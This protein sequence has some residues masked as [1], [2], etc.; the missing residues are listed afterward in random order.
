[1][2]RGMSY[3]NQPITILPLQATWLM[4]NLHHWELYV[5]IRPPVLPFTLLS[6]CACHGLRSAWLL[7]INVTNCNG[8][9]SRGCSSYGEWQEATG[10][11]VGDR[12]S[13]VCV[14]KFVSVFF[15]GETLGE[16]PAV[17]VQTKIGCRF[18]GNRDIPAV[19]VTHIL[20]KTKFS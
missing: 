4:S 14:S 5:R 12:S 16:C 3:I 7:C 10:C 18:T 13:P 15:C 9:L 6:H 2:L 19:F 17:F 11:Q 8:A 20:S 1:M